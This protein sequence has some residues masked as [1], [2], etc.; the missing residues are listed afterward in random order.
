MGVAPS[1]L[2]MALDGGEWSA[3]LALL[4]GK[5]PVIPSVKQPWWAPGPIPAVNRALTNQSI[6]GHYNHW[7]VSLHGHVL[8]MKHKIP[9]KSWVVGVQRTQLG[10]KSGQNLFKKHPF[11]ALL[12]NNIHKCHSALWTAHVE[13]KEA[14]I[15][16]SL[17]W[18]GYGMD[19]QASIPSRHTA[20]RTDLGPKQP[21]AKHVPQILSKGVKLT[22]HNQLH[23]R[24]LLRLKKAPLLHGLHAGSG[25]WTGK[26]AIVGYRHYPIFCMKRLSKL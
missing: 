16:Q 18:S 13:K 10:E 7:A 17:S 24:V 23:V 1:I 2:T 14:R 20:S 25:L 4:L 11:H 21:L 9:L 12:V 6:P 5:H 3:S 19:D 8:C 22:I 15:A 26:K